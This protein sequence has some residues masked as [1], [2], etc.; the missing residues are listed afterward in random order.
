[1]NKIILLLFILCSLNGISAESN[2]EDS[3]KQLLVYNETL[4][5]S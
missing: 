5:D 1:M 2:P 3:T 4:Q